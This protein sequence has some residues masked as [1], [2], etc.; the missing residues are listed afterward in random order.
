V[1][2][3]K[4][5]GGSALVDI[6]H[7]KLYRVTNLVLLCAGSLAVCRSLYCFLA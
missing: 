4:L 7:V 6:L 1:E 2:L 3:P 5:L